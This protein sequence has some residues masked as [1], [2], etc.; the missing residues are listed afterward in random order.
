MVAT[1]AVYARVEAPAVAPHP[2]GLFS[3]ASPESPS[4][5]DWQIGIS[6]ESWACLDA[7]VTRSSCID[8]LADAPPKEF[9]VC[10]N[11]QSVKPFTVYSGVKLTG[12]SQEVARSEST[13]ILQ[14]AEEYA[15]EKGLWASLGT[16]VTESAALSPIGAL[17]LVENGLAT[18]YMGLGVIHMTPGMAVRLGTTVLIEKG[19]HLETIAG[20]PVVVGS[21]YAAAAPQAIYGTGQL[22][23]MR[24][25][26]DTVEAFALSVNDLL[27][28]AERTYVVAWDCYAVGSLVSPAT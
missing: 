12:Q 13:A 8:G 23:I 16:A 26:V 19:N 7:N 17:A 1:S 11:T 5:T 27:V 3:V 4:G 18:G 20:T 21:G 10:P 6:F 15:A 14:N 25:P 28:L 2:Y 24:G 22:K 9:E